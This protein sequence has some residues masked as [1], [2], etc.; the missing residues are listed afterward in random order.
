MIEGQLH[1]MAVQNQIQQHLKGR[2]GGEEAKGMNE[3]NDHL[4]ELLVFERGLSSVGGGERISKPW[5]P[6]RDAGLGVIQAREEG[7]GRAV[8][9]AAV[10]EGLPFLQRLR[11]RHV[12]VDAVTVV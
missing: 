12:Q 10:L 8:E 2:E 7:R 9:M 5:R 3:Q 6:R 11:Q 4:S 1:G